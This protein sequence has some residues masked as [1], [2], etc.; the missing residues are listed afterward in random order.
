MTRIR[1]FLVLVAALLFT[2]GAHAQVFSGCWNQGTSA[3]AFDTASMDTGS[4]A[5]GSVTLGCQPQGTA[6]FLRYCLYLPQGSP[7]T[8]I[9]PRRM[10]NA[11]SALLYDLYSDPAR[12]SVIGPPPSGGGYPVYTNVVAVAASSTQFAVNIPVYGRVLA[13][14]NVPAG[15]YHSQLP[16][17]SLAWAFAAGAPPADCMQGPDKG[18]ISFYFDASATIS[19]SCRIGL[20]TDMNFGSVPDLVAALQSTATITVRCPTGTPW[21]LGLNNG[22]FSQASTRRMRSPKGFVTYELYRDAARSQRWGASA[23]NAVT[24]VGQGINSPQASTVYG[25]VPAQGNPVAGT[26]T[27]VIVVTLTY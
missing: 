9:A 24:G 4:E 7:L 5:T 25:L 23:P 27:D 22:L 21:S 6:G 17:A 16:G 13:G 10:N 11:G 12:T 20:T 8:G 14:Q 18:T 15:N 1:L 3:I 19:A 26:Y 2:S